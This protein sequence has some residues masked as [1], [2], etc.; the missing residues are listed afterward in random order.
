MK[1]NRPR[2]RRTKLCFVLYERKQK[3][4]NLY[5]NKQNPVSWQVSADGQRMIG[6]MILR[7]NTDGEDILGLKI[8]GGKTLPSSRKGAVIEKVKRGSIAD[9]EGHLKPGKT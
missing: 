5:W 6:H 1:K 7:K 2:T 3:T 4:R 9:Q 8:V